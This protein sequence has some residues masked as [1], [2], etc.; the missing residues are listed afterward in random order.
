[1]TV[2]QS[3]IRRQIAGIATFIATFKR[4]LVSSIETLPRTLNRESALKSRRVSGTVPRREDLLAR[5]G[6]EE[7]KREKERERERERGG[8]GKRNHE[9]RFNCHIAN[10]SQLLREQ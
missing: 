8:G 9:C 10:D 1:M 3:E 5:A 7:E 2:I 4:L 6:K